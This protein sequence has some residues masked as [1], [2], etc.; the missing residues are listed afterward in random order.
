MARFGRSRTEA[1]LPLNEIAGTAS[2]RETQ[3]GV[4]GR[5]L[6]TAHRLGT[7]VPESWVVV[8]DVFRQVVHSALPPGHDPASLLRT[9]QR[10]TGIE[11]AARSRERLL[12]VVLDD[13][14]EE[15]VDRAWHALSQVA[16]WGLAVRASAV[17]A[18]QGIARAAGLSCT[19]MPL[20]TREDVAIAIRKAWAGAASEATLSYLKARRFRDVAVAVLVQPVVPAEAS[21]ILV[22]DE[23]L[24]SDAHPSANAFPRRLAIATSGLITDR[25]DLSTAEVVQFDEDGTTFSLRL[26][27]ST[28]RLVVRDRR[29]EWDSVPSGQRILDEDRLAELAELARSLESLGHPVVRCAL[30]EGGAAVVVD[31][32]PLA[33]LGFPGAGTTETLWARVA[34]GEAPP[35]PLTPLSRDL[36]TFSVLERVRSAEAARVRRPRRAGKLASV[37]TTVD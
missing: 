1:V 30:P 27:T 32:H 17:V 36:L 16:P 2:R 35:G 33:H 4:L 3:V 31:V 10:E 24:F 34:V 6:A 14:V 23:R 11:R 22:T 15:E 37:V 5:T 29:F 13:N 9:I 28:R 12:S 25:V 18:D 7:T 20:F 8:A 26:P 21:V 19:D